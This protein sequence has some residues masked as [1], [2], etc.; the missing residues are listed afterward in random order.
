MT[1]TDAAQPGQATTDTDTDEAEAHDLQAAMAGLRDLFSTLV[2]PD[3]MQLQDA[4]GNRYDASAV[5]PARAQI[6]VMQQLHALWER[7]LPV[8]FGADA[9]A[10]AGLVVALAADEVVLDG[11]ADAFLAAHPKVVSAAVQA[12]DREGDGYTHPA[13]LFPIEELVA[14]LVPF[15]VRFAARA[16]DLIAA[17]TTPATSPTA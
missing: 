1:D 15:F 14:G 3:R 16:G 10:V 11:L 13:D 8:S 5:L 2:P 6:K 4:L 9:S 17:T 12:S 7:E